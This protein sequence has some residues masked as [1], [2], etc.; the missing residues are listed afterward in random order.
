MR[1]AFVKSVCLAVV[2]CGSM[3]GI[4][5][6]VRSAERTA[7]QILKEID[8]VKLPTLDSKA[9]R[10]IDPRSSTTRTDAATQAPRSG[11]G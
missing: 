3:V 6:P 10:T 2:I 9:R 7:D 11:P 5:A 1:H 4:I 8:A